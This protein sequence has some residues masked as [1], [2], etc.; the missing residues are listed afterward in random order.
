MITDVYRNNTME[1]CEFCQV[2]DLIVTTENVT[3]LNCSRVQVNAPF[4]SPRLNPTTLES[5]GQFASSQGFELARSFCDLFLKNDCLVEEIYRKGLNIKDRFKLKNTKKIFALAAFDIF[6]QNKIYY[7]P[8]LTSHFF[9]QD[10]KNLKK[11]PA[12]ICPPRPCEQSLN[13]ALTSFCYKFDILFSDQKEIM[14]EVLSKNMKKGLNPILWLSVILCT[15]LHRKKIFSL[16][17]SASLCAHHFGLNRCH[18]LRCIRQFT[19]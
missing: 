4:F 2:S 10:L 18:L 16:Q 11:H 15:N 7:D 5:D 19:E 1:K 12:F 8:E 3:C 14:S 13:S 9:G 6:T 17:R